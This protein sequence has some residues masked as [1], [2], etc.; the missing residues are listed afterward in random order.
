MFDWVLNA[1]LK[2][3]EYDEFFWIKNLFKV[4]ARDVRITSKNV[5]LASILCTLKRVLPMGS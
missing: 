3:F 5:I 1:R 4:K 2:N